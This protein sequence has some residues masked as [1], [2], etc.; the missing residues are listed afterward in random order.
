MIPYIR[1]IRVILFTF[2][3]SSVCYQCIH[4]SNRNVSF[5]LQM[6]IISAEKTNKINTS[7]PG[8][9]LLSTSGSQPSI[10]INCRQIRSHHRL[11][12]D[13]IPLLPVVDS[14]PRQIS[15]QKPSSPVPVVNPPDRFLERFSIPLY[16]SF[17]V[18]R[19]Y[20]RLATK[21][22]ELNNGRISID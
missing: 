3:S 9:C 20:R 12:E 2:L 21:I 10:F 7:L 1:V 15:K 19:T 6:F 8:I 5:F 11:W 4:S 17:D 13:E 14:I 16:L 22:F 18:S